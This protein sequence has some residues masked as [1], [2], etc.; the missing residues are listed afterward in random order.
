M[1][2]TIYRYKII[3]ANW[4]KDALTE[5]LLKQIVDLLMKQPFSGDD[6]KAQFGFTQCGYK[7]GKVFGL[8]VQK[9]IVDPNFRT[10]V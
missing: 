4:G 6:P 1:N 7:D 5:Y 2:A 8:F 3:G 10:I 9:F